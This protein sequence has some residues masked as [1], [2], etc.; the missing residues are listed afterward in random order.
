M[1]FNSTASGR[2][3]R[4]FSVIIVSRLSS[5]G[6]A[7]ST[8]TAVS[9]FLSNRTKSGLLASTDLSVMIR[10]SQRSFALSLLST[11]SGLHL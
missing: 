6:I 3:F 10:V 2:S 5:S 9:A 1:S 7:I 4:C 8:I 11:C